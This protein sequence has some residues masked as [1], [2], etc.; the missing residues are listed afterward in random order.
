M[1]AD[2]RKPVR[3]TDYGACPKCHSETEPGEMLLDGACWPA[4]LVD[5]IA[6]NRK[7]KS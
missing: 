3:A 1:T 2:S 6:L 4:C 5:M 7:A